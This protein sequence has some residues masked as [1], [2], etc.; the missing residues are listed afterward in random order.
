MKI[1]TG[2]APKKPVVKMHVESVSDSEEEPNDR[3]HEEPEELEEC[4]SDEWITWKNSIRAHNIFIFVLI[5]HAQS[6]HTRKKYL[7][8]D[9]MIFTKLIINHRWQLKTFFLLC[10]SSRLCLNQIFCLVYFSNNSCRIYV[11]KLMLSLLDFAREDSALWPSSR[12][13]V[14]TH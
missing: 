11:Y 14:K 8:V 7:L 6:A 13:A 12:A 9:F 1:K 5:M 2:K 4:E 3:H 10:L